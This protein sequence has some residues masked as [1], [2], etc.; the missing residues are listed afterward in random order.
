MANIFISYRREDSADVTGRIHDRL[1]EHFGES[2]VFMDVDDIPLGVDFSKYIDEKVGKCEVLLAVVG[3][4]W[5]STSDDA[6]NRRLDLPSDYV[7]I[8]IESA[9]KRNIP[10]IPLLVRRASMPG[11]E[12]LPESIREFS[13]RNGMPVRPDPDFRTDCDRLIEGLERDRTGTRPIVSNRNKTVEIKPKPK[14]KIL[15]M[16]VAGIAV[17]G[18]LFGVYLWYSGS[19]GPSPTIVE[20]QANPNS[21]E[22][23]ADATLR[24]VTRNARKVV[25]LPDIGTVSASGS[26]VISP[27]ESTIYTLA[28]RG[29]DSGTV[30]QRLSIQVNSQPAATIPQ[31]RLT[32]AESTIKLGESTTL[33]W[34][35]KDASEIEIQPGIGSVEASGSVKI[36]PRR[37]TSYTLT[38][39][40]PAG[41]ATSTTLVK[42]ERTTIQARPTII[43]RPAIR[44][45]Q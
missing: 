9:L 30:K 28:A 17:I 25:I 13:K 38:A 19:R 35:T 5:L 18:A 27:T 10:V 40:S 24:W 39:K 4:D 2:A 6:G 15:T 33:S 37:N 31:S 11:A 32:V 16:A 20:F 41:T 43:T 8:E 42:V 1:A 34:R 3:R 36:S 29:S 45:S 21:I 22:H 44:M 7:R 23:G 14:P 26:K 12:D